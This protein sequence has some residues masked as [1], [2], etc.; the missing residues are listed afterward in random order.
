MFERE[1]LELLEYPKV[2]AMLAGFTRTL[3]A[4]QRAEN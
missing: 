2:T 1:Y 3:A 4:R